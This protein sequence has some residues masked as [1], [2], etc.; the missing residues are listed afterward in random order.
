MAL[1]LDQFKPHAYELG[2]TKVFGDELTRHGKE[3]TGWLRT[4]NAERLTDTYWATSGTGLPSVKGIGEPYVVDQIFDGPRKTFGLTVYGNSLV[5]QDEAI[6]WDNY[7]IFKG[8]AKDMARN[9]IERENLTAFALINHAMDASPTADFQDLNGQAI[10][11]TNKTRMDGGTWKNRHSSNAGLSYKA[12][13]EALV[14]LSR[15]V[16]ER[17]M[18]AKISSKMLLIASEQD[19]IAREIFGSSNVA[20][21]LSNTKNTL[22]GSGITPMAY[23]YITSTTAWLL[24]NKEIPEIWFRFGMPPTMR[25]GSDPKTDNRYVTTKRSMSTCVYRTYGWYGSSGDGA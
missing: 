23:P 4:A 9:H 2:L 3:Y 19:Y 15:T 14:D 6:Y 18:F 8:L 5:I 24:I 7:G 13:Q 25:S 20:H 21:E 11:A 22:M 1:T 12:V 10:C 16:N 17:G